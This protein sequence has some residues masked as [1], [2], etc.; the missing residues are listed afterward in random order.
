MT[1]CSQIEVTPE[2]NRIYTYIICP[3]HISVNLRLKE[4]KATIFLVIFFLNFSFIN[5]YS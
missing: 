4:K 3:L 5:V 1:G 2:L